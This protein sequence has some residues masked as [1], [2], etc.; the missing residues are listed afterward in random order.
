[1]ST[2]TTRPDAELAYRGLDAAKAHKTHFNMDDWAQSPNGSPIGLEDLT[3]PECGTTAC[4]AGWIVV[5]AGYRL[6]G[7]GVV[8]DTQGKPVGRNA[9]SLAIELLG[10]DFDQAGDLFFVDNDEIDD[11]VAAIFG[12]RPAVTA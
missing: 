4:F 10:I 7:D 3:G 5:L 2:I 11:A 8:F 12:P 9:E 1:M 6:N